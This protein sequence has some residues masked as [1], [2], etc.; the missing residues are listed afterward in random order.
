[1]VLLE[2]DLETDFGVP[3]GEKDK[4]AKKDLYDW[5]CDVRMQKHKKQCK[6]MEENL[7][8]ATKRDNV[9]IFLKALVMNVV[10]SRKEIH[11]VP[12]NDFDLKMFQCV[13]SD[14]LNVIVDTHSPC[15]PTNRDHDNR[16]FSRGESKQEIRF[17]NT[18]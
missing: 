5:L 11:S 6:V 1:M 4:V 2:S 3:V 13:A 8:E 12:M 15:R 14:S 10:R 17:N 16:Q 7:A 18:S 9:R